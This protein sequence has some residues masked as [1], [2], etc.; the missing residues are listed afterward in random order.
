MNIRFGPKIIR[1]DYFR[2]IR[3]L[4]DSWANNVFTDYLPHTS[5]VPVRWGG[6]EPSVPFQS[7][8]CFDCFAFV[9]DG[10]GSV[11][12]DVSSTDGV[13]GPALH[14]PIEESLCE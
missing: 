11:V 3:L 14:Q 2:N 1:A 10:S 13:F 12:R 7:F 5:I 8:G 4:G 9:S 6:D